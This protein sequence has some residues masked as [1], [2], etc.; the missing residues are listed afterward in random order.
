M[1]AR[2]RGY[3]AALIATPVIAVA[4]TVPAAHATATVPTASPGSTVTSASR[5]GYAVVAA[6]GK[7]FRYV[8][9]QV[10]SPGTD[11]LAAPEAGGEV[12]ESVGLG[13]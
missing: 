9:A 13:G 12:V 1:S 3:V 2:T 8:Q 11:C 4:W 6:E 5:S 10:G 7:R